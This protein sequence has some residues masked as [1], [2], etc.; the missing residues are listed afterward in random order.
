M[1]R[2]LM[3]GGDPDVVEAGRMILVREGYTVAMARDI[4]DAVALR[5]HFQP[6]LLFI[7]VIG[8]ELTD[9]VDLGTSAYAEGL[10]I[11][12]LVMAT[13]GRGVAFY[14]YCGN[15]TLEPAPDFPE[16]PME[17]AALRKNVQY[18]LERGCKGHPLAE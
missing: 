14:M 5:D 10:R 8:H 2:I 16:K 1:T 12:A 3:L 15:G 4:K 7:D 6:S 11:P 18:A 13:K 17:P 9:A